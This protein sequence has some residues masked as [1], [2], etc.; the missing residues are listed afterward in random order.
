MQI[1]RGGQNGFP[2]ARTVLN[3]AV[4]PGEFRGLPSANVGGVRDN[5]VRTA[6]SK[7]NVFF[8]VK[9]LVELGIAP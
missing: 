3:E 9:L 5:A 6:A 4:L 8:T 7:S 2:S 1:M